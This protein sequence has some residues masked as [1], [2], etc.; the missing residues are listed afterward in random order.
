M[1][2]L[3][4]ILGVLLAIAL[5]VINVVWLENA[6]CLDDEKRDNQGPAIPRATGDVPKV[7]S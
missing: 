1:W 6:G 7:D 2:Y 3:I 5:A 4:W